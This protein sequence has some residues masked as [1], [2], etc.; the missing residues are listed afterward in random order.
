MVNLFSDYQNKLCKKK[1]VSM[2]QIHVRHRNVDNSKQDK[3]KRKEY[4]ISECCPS[5]RHIS[6]SYPLISLFSF[7]C[8]CKYQKILSR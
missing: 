8:S 7:Y 5:K 6:C 4:L 1:Y 2:N 3:E